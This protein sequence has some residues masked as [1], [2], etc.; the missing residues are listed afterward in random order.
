MRV[1]WYLNDRLFAVSEMPDSSRVRGL[2]RTPC[3]VA[4]F[5]PRCG[6]IWARFVAGPDWEVDHHKCRDCQRPDEPTYSVFDVPGSL[7]R[8]W[9]AEYTAALP[10]TVLKREAELLAVR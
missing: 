3:S 7:L 4:F 6:N 1:S 5:C 9:D 8:E 2:W 10:H